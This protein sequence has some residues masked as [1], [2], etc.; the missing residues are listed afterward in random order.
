MQLLLQHAS[1]EY[2]LLDVKYAKYLRA[3]NNVALTRK[4]DIKDFGSTA[5]VCLNVMFS[6]PLQ[7]VIMQMLSSRRPGLPNVEKFNYLAYYFIQTYRHCN[8]AP[9]KRTPEKIECMQ[10]RAASVV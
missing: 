5:Q 3:P 6:G 4:V 1:Y 10:I 7:S 9:S 2:D 8:L